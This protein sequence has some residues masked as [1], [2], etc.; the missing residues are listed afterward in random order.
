MISLFVWRLVDNCLPNKDKLFLR[1]MQNLVSFY[2]VV[3]YNSN[4]TAEH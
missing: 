2:C 4:E 1:G 3:G